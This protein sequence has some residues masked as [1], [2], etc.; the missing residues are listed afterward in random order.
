MKNQILYSMN[1]EWTALYWSIP[2]KEVYGRG[3]LLCDLFFYFKY[4]I[5]NEGIKP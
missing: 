5:A 1:T 4:K 2:H 3:I